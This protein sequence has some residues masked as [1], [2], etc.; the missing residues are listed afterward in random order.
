M[1]SK[2]NFIEALIAISKCSPDQA[3]KVL[4]FYLKNKIAKID[5]HIGQINVRHG[6]FLDKDVILRAIAH[7]S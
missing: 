4:S 7:T 6:A 3:E 2:E 5:P 1:T